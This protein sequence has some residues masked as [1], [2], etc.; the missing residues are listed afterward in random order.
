M[1]S[2][3]VEMPA[4]R[5]AAWVSLNLQGQAQRLAMSIP[6]QALVTGG[7]INGV[8]VDALTFLMH[9]LSERY[10]P[11]GEESRLKAMTDIFNFRKIA[12]RISGRPAY[13]F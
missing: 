13:S 2:I 3:L 6:P 7:L 5:E 1:W 9:S 11:L 8:Q 4:S 12:R 10:A